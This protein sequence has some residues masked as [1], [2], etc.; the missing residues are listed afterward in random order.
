MMNRG[1]EDDVHAPGN[2]RMCS[3]SWKAAS[4]NGPLTWYWRHSAYP[5]KLQ[6][7][8]LMCMVSSAILHENPDLNQTLLVQSGLM[9]SSSCLSAH[10]EKCP[11]DGHAGAAR[12][13]CPANADKD[14]LA[15]TNRP[16]PL[17]QTDT[18]SEATAWK[19][20]RSLLHSH[21]L[22]SP[23]RLLCGALPIQSII[24]QLCCSLSSLSAASH[25]R[26]RHS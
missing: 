22:S 3:C 9:N 7:V 2:Q 24:T 25:E 4:A 5:G 26:G 15:T 12:L 19:S 11:L 20:W 1:T 13:F 23:R 21:Q 18:V 17:A 10:V 14:L 16:W 6:N 8:C